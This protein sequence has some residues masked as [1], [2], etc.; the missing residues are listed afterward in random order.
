MRTFLQKHLD[1]V[2]IL[3]GAAAI[4]AGFTLWL[5]LAAGLISGG[6]ELI[7]LGVLIGLGGK[8]Q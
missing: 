8:S 6:V 7:A 1:D 5:G 3:S 2:L 4:A